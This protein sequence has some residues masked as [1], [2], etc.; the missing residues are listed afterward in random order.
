MATFAFS[1]R[2]PLNTIFEGDV[3]AVRLKTD[4]GQMEILPDHATLAGTILFSRVNIHSG[5]VEQVY[6][7]RQGSV[8]VD[9]QGVV[10]VTALDAQEAESLSVKSVEEYLLY[11]N[12]QLSGEQQLNDYQKK[13]LSEQRSALEE[14]LSETK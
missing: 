13:F 5:G 10:R 12:K 4:L 7:I 2:T 14:T 6:I 11:L 9:S 3:D 1:L 8:S